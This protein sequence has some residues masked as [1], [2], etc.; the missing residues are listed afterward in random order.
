MHIFYIFLELEYIYIYVYHIQNIYIYI[1]ILIYMY[2]CGS[3]HA[4]YVYLGSSNA[5]NEE[6]RMLHIVHGKWWFSSQ[7]SHNSLEKMQ[8]THNPVNV[9]Y[10]QLKLLHPS[11][12]RWSRS[13]FVAANFLASFYLSHN[14]EWTQRSLIC[15]TIQAARKPPISPQMMLNFKLQDWPSFNVRNHQ[16]RPDTKGGTNLKINMSFRFMYAYT[17]HIFVHVPVPFLSLRKW[18]C[19]VRTWSPVVLVAV[20]RDAPSIQKFG[21]CEVEK[22]MTTF[23]T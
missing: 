20:L 17:V 2:I 15:M 16:I 14:F 3:W 6:R 23:K 21:E 10:W 1:Y 13:F 19:C 9:R 7:L 22:K 4:T 12:L 18:P 8:L 11:W 5:Q